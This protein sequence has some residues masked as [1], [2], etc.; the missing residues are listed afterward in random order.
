MQVALSGLKIAHS[1]NSTGQRS[2]LN[3]KL[4]KAMKG[5][6]LQ[7]NA[8]NI[9]IIQGLS[10]CQMCRDKTQAKHRDDEGGGVR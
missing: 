1:Y 4:F 5:L 7:F 9:N 2:A 8:H 6:L 3:S 10:V